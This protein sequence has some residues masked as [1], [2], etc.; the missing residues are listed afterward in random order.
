MRGSRE[1]N[2]GPHQIFITPCNG[3]VIFLYGVKLFGT[4]EERLDMQ[5]E[6]VEWL[7]KE[8]FK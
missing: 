2:T 4:E 8:F 6:D 5:I 3:F 1:T 7:M